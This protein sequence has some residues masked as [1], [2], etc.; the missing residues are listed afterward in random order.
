M[1]WRQVSG[2]KFARFYICRPSTLQDCKQI[3]RGEVCKKNNSYQKLLS[4][5]DYETTIFNFGWI[6]FPYKKTSTKQWEIAE[7]LFRIKKVIQSS[8]WK[9]CNSFS[10]LNF[11]FSSQSVKTI[12][13]G[14]Q[15]FCHLMK[16]LL[17]WVN[18]S[19][20]YLNINNKQKVIQFFSHVYLFLVILVT[21][22]FLFFLFT[23]IFYFQSLFFPS[24]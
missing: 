20:K 14:L 19:H 7:N 13:V 21:V 12:S 23:R 2:R 24:R 17:F 18:F 11:F 6:L 16:E 5:N 22:D 10:T 3:R 15:S 1:N 4:K 9:A 8:E